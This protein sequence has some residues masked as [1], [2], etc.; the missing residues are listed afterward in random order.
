MRTLKLAL[1]KAALFLSPLEITCDKVV[2]EE[3]GCYAPLKYL[4]GFP[5]VLALFIAGCCLLVYGWVRRTIQAFPANSLE[6]A[7]LIIGFNLVYF[8]GILPFLVN[9]RVRMPVIPFMLAVGAYAVYALWRALLGRAFL[10][11]AVGAAA[12]MLL[13]TVCSIPFLPLRSRPCPLA[14]Q[15][16]GFLP[17]HQSSA[18][19]RESRD[20]I[21]LGTGMTYMH[22]RPAKARTK[23]AFEPLRCMRRETETVAGLSGSALPSGVSAGQAPAKRA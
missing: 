13:Y 17:A 5:L 9:G 10:K 12:I 22:Q 2:Q 21:D 18:G 11:A 7:V 3:K 23:G 19:N 15:A 4:P 1:K 8:A 6:F 14:L 16:G 20:L